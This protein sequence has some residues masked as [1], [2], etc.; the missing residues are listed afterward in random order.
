MY[1]NDLEENIAIAKN[2][3]WLFDPKKIDPKFKKQYED[4]NYGLL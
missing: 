4:Q 2:G 1:K 3:N